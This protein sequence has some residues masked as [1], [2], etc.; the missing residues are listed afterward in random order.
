MAT[1]SLSKRYRPIHWKSSI[2]VHNSM[3]HPVS[4]ESFRE[5]PPYS[6]PSEWNKIGIV[7]KHQS[8][9]MTCS[10]NII[11]KEYLFSLIKSVE[12]G[13][14]PYSTVCNVYLHLKVLNLCPHRRTHRPGV[15]PG[16]VPPFI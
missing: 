3:P 15:T 5:F 4:I 6:L 16:L 7:I 10:I 8:D 13:S 1:I 2:F 12:S 9:K 11:L 14:M